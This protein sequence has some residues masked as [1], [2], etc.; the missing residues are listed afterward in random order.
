MK[1]FKGFKFIDYITLFWVAIVFI[2]QFRIF[3]FYNYLWLGCLILW[4]I[5]ML[6]NHRFLTYVVRSKICFPIIFVGILALLVPVIIGENSMFNRYLELLQVPLLAIVYGFNSFLGKRTVNF[7]ITLISCVLI[8]YPVISTIKALVENPY[9]ARSIK[10]DPSVEYILMMN[11][12]GGYSLVY[13]SLLLC[14][15]IISAILFLK[16]RKMTFS[17]GLIIAFAFL[18]FFLIVMSNYFTA[19]VV[20]LLSIFLLLVL[21]KNKRVI[22]LIIPVFFVYGVAKNEINYLVIDGLLNV[23]QEGGK[24][25]DR[26]QELK[27]ANLN[28]VEVQNV[29]SRSGTIDDD[30]KLIANYPLSGFFLSGDFNLGL[31]G[32]H[33]T[34]LDTLAFYG[35]IMGGAIVF[36]ILLPLYHLFKEQTEY[37]AKLY[38]LLTGAVFI[39]LITANNMTPSMGYV[40]Y[41]MFP[42]LLD[43]LKTNQML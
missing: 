31:V 10:N 3:S 20:L 8:T 29:D 27:Y 4:I 16:N 13:S 37:Q 9:I 30:L 5:A 11:G 32:Q 25:Y 33:S 7:K 22:Y 43:N 12:I 26:L 18:L 24:N 21:E 28:A 6:L 35:L 40:V 19:L 15:I 41:F 42:S 1:F 2:P 38:V 36:V 34:V 17:K 39:V 23:V 14:I